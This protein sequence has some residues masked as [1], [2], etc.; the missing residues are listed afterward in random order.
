ML[1]TI[2]NIASQFYVANA[3]TNQYLPGAGIYFITNQNGS[4]LWISA[5][6]QTWLTNNMLAQYATTNVLNGWYDTNG[7][8]SNAYAGSVA[9]STNY[10]ATNTATAVSNALANV[11]IN[12]GLPFVRSTNGTAYSLDIADN[13]RFGTKTNYFLGTNWIGAIGAGSSGAAGTY[14]QI[15]NGVWTNLSSPG[16][17]IVY[18]GGT[19]YLNSNSATLYSAFSVNGFWTLGP[20]GVAPVPLVYYA[21]EFRV[22][23][24]PLIG[25]I[26]ATNLQVQWNA[27]ISGMSNNVAASN[28]V[29]QVASQ[30]GGAGGAERGAELR[31]AG[32]LRDHVPRSPAR[33]LVQGRL[34][35]R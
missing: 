18:I 33:V 32:Q 5:S 15:A 4:I 14:Q 25:Y 27:A 11:A 31:R 6:N 13:L 12:T 34:R 26:I 7:A 2:T 9:F 17:S 19:Y 23:G 22:T 24:T 16:F 21:P 29:A 30:Y 28:F 20:S 35:V 1:G 3:N 10:A 8:A